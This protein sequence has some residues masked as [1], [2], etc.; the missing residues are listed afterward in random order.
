MQTIER[1]RQEATDVRSSARLAGIGYVLIFVLAIF[2]NFFV[3]EGLVETG[4]PETTFANIS[5]S[6]GLFRL[7]LVAFLLIFLLDVVIAWALHVVFRSRNRDLSLLTAWMRIVYTVMLGVGLV[8]FFEILHLVDGTSGFAP[9]QAAPAV[10]SALQSFDAAWLIGL[11]AFGIHLLLLGYLVLQTQGA[12]RLL[13]YLL[14]AAGVAYIADTVAHAI[15]SDYAQVASVFL[16]VV[17]I[18]SVIAEGWLGLWLLTSRK[19]EVG[20]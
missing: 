19:L 13:G 14:M 9:D 5:E 7:G 20:A 15:L 8:Y 3:R 4:D 16:A 10:M 11:A 17:A 2:A 6:L 12:S 18:P 1:P